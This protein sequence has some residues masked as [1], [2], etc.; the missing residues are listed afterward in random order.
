VKWLVYIHR[1]NSETFL[2]EIV[3]QVKQ[4]NKRRCISESLQTTQCKDNHSLSQNTIWKQQKLN[5][6]FNILDSIVS[7]SPIGTWL[8]Y[9]RNPTL[10][11]SPIGSRFTPRLISAYTRAQKNKQNR[12][13]W[14]KVLHATRHKNGSFRRRSSQPISW[15]SAEE[16][17]LAQ[18]KQTSQE[19]NSPD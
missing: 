6:K 13:D 8:S 10:D 19:Q 15:H 16:T 9:T 4:P 17:K 7:F 2:H 14:V 1:S 18:R 3:V 5:R 11:Q 12:I